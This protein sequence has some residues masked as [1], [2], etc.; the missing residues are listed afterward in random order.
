MYRIES[1]NTAVRLALSC[2]VLAGHV[3][4]PADEWTPNDVPGITSYGFDYGC[5]Q[6]GEADYAAVD[7]LLGED[8][9]IAM[10]QARLEGRFSEAQSSQERLAKLSGTEDPEMTV[11]RTM[12]SAAEWGYDGQQLF[13][14]AGQL[15]SRYYGLELRLETEPK[16]IGDDPETSATEGFDTASVAI[17]DVTPAQALSA[18]EAFTALPPDVYQAF[19]I[20]AIEFYTIKN[21]ALDS[22]YVS[23]NGV[24]HQNLNTSHAIRARET[25]IHEISHLADRYF[26]PRRGRDP[27]YTT[28]NGGDIYTDEGYAREGYPDTGQS[29]ETWRKPFL[30]LIMD[31]AES[32]EGRITPGTAEL[33]LSASIPES[34]PGEVTAVSTYA[35]TSPKE[36]KAELPAIMFGYSY[37][38]GLTSVTDPNKPKLAAKARELL[39]RWHSVIPEATAY[40]IRRFNGNYNQSSEAEWREAEAQHY[41]DLSNN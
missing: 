24:T 27:G 18:M 21:G 25:S 13:R 17:Q 30:G 6:P 5:L 12:D 3:Q 19:D 23:E 32:S 40:L 22:G 36:D 20:K 34:R 8:A 41:F 15:A 35:L 33:Q 16:V 31:M 37:P 2:A 9:G 10:G 29:L 28:H 39:A 4:V 38:D 14:L 26:C 7:Q 1:S 11:R